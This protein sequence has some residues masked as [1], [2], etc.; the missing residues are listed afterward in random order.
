M[1]KSCSPFVCLAFS[2]EESKLSFLTHLL[3]LFLPWLA[4]LKQGIY[5][6]NSC[7]Q[8][9]LKLLPSPFKS[10]EEWRSK[11]C[12]MKWSFDSDQEEEE[13]ARTSI[14]LQEPRTCLLL[15]H[16]LFD[17]KVISASPSLVLT[18]LPLFVVISLLLPL[19]WVLDFYVFVV[20]LSRRKRTIDAF[21][22]FFQ[23]LSLH[24]VFWSLFNVL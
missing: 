11:S 16:C 20:V 9:L 6:I 13:C 3:L 19:L 10:S 8:K 23:S 17:P 22:H 4:L 24:I 12:L 5:L 18:W 15:I 2:V 1:K 7:V 21:Y 14:E